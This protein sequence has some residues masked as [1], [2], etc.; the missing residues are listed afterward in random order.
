M[1][2]F[3]EKLKDIQ[4]NEVLVVIVVL[5]L[6]QL[7]LNSLNIIH[8]DSIFIDIFLIFYFIFKLKDNLP[9]KNDFSEVFAGDLLKYILVIVVLNVFL[10]YGFLYLSNYLLEI[11]PP[12]SFISGYNVSDSIMA[13][14]VLATI[15]L[16]PI[17]EE[18]LFRGVF[19]N[20]LKIIVPTL[21]SVLISSLL[22]ASLH[23]YGSVISAFIFGLCMS[24][25]YIKTDNILVPMFAHFLNNL[26][27]E[28]IVVM[29]PTHIIFTNDTVI[30]TISILAIVSFVIISNF[31]IKELNNLK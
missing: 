4:L 14:G 9:D 11:F 2:L 3:N 23:S 28:I 12:L 29:D 1:S 20:R 8:F 24:I 7:I 26:L 30:I 25:L 31:L 6:I 13:L 21:F 27:A 16:S 15:F 19:Y 5:F 18:L 17:V 10:S 22:F